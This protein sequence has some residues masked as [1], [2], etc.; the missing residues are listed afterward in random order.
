MKTF[1]IAA[2]LTLSLIAPAALAQDTTSP[3]TLKASTTDGDGQITLGDLFDNAGA[4]ASVIVGYRNGPSAILDAAV[5]QSIAGRAG[6]YWDNPKGLRRIIVTQG[7]ESTP[8]A[9]TTPTAAND[10]AA[11]GAAIVIRRSESV[12]VTWSANGLSLT[13]SGTAQKDGA[14]GDLIQIENPASKK[15][16]DAVV[17]APGQ[18]IAGQAADQIRSKMLLSSR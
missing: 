8:S 1:I 17:I 14:I 10:T 13:L 15:M 6:V 4:A 3:L 5:V 18:A 16:I 7:A 2:I 9:R 11:S 12:S